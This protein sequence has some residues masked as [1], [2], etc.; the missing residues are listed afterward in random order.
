MKVWNTESVLGLARD[1]M[2]ARVLL[3]GAELDVFNLLAEAPKSRDE[4]CAA[5]GTSARGTAILL[6]ALS[7]M[8]LLSKEDG[9][10]MCPEHIAE[11]MSGRSPKSVLP[12]VK[13]AATLW[14][15]WT[16]LTDIVKRGI[17][18]RPGGVFVDPAELEAFI[19]AMHVVG[20]HGARSIADAA[21]ATQSLKL[22]DVGGA[23]GTYAEAFLTKY[24]GMRATIFDRPEVIALARKRLEKTGLLSRIDLVPGDFYKD[25]LPGGYDLALLSAI[26]H[27]NSP[28][29]NVALYRKVYDALVPG[30][31]I[32]IR[33]HVMSPNR[34]EPVG[35]AMFAVNMLVATSGGN[36][37]TFDEIK[38]SLSTAGFE[39]VCLVQSGEMMDGLVEA[40]RR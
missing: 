20:V 15:R 26:I 14:P 25:T 13:H 32:L 4:V 21:G 34:T 33:D 5:L 39:D 18:D 38:E 28:E 2:E 23:T 31:R 3:S 1:F 11:L 7:A 17:A 37:Y 35:G 30:G 16:E 10:Y 36:C 40:F 22:L 9:M 24:K 19:G 27:Q 12:M 29:Q 8:G 6:D